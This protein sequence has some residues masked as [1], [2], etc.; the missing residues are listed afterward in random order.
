MTVDPGDI[1]VEAFPAPDY[2]WNLYKL[3][4]ADGVHSEHSSL[5]EWAARVDELCKQVGRAGVDLPWSDD[6]IPF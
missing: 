2:A 6:D 4:H 5:E 3:S 1:E